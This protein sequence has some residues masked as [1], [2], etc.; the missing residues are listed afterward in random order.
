MIQFAASSHPAADVAA[1]VEA[2]E[3]ALR[4]HGLVFQCAWCTRFLVG[5]QLV[6][7]H[8]LPDRL[9]AVR[10]LLERRISHGV[11]GDCAGR[12]AGS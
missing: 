12:V 2:A 9:D 6:E 11:C 3:A 5:G 10:L 4:A 8:A 7:S 1:V